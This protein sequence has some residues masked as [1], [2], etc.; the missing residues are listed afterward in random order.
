[1]KQGGGLLILGNQ[2]AHNLEIRDLNGLLGRFGLALTNRYHDAKVLKIPATVPEIGGLRWAF[3]TGN[4]VVLTP[5]HP[6]RPTAW[7]TNDV[8][9]PTATGKRNEPGIL[10]AAAEL[11][12]GRV[13]VATDAG[14]ITRNA[15]LELGIGDLTLRGQDNGE[16]LVRI[17]G[18]LANRSGPR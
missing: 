10:L 11:G 18:W 1:V 4:E 17:C 6:G 16:L 9:L 15:L 7:V 8:Q 12:R 14:W 2:E 3:Y 5:G 13:V